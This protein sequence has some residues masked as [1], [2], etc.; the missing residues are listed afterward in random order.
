MFTNLT[1][2]QKMLGIG[3]ILGVFVLIL[4][5]SA[6]FAI[7][8]LSGRFENLKNEEIT[9]QMEAIKVVRDQN[10][11][12]RVTRNIMLGADY[13]KNMKDLAASSEKILKSFAAME[14][15]AG[16]EEEKKEV[17]KAGKAMQAWLED[18]KKRMVSLKDTP[19]EKRATYFHEYEKGVTPLAMELR[20]S[21]SKIAEKAE[22]DFD[23]GLV[24]YNSLAGKASTT[25]IMIGVI[26]V[27]FSA[28]VFL[29]L[30]STILK[31]VNMM[32]TVAETIASGDLTKGTVAYRNNDEMGRLARALESM[33]AT[34]KDMI[35]GIKTA[36]A[37][38]AAG[39]HQLSAS[40][41][42][43]TRN[44]SE[45][46]S[47]SSQI[48]TSAEEMTQT[49]LDVAKNA[50]T[51]AM[52][53]ADTA[54]TANDG[55]EVVEKSA[56]ES[57]SVAEVVGQSSSV[58]QTLGEKSKQIGE[59]VAVINDIA[60]Q[61]NLLALNAAIEAARAG[62]QGRGFAVV[63]DEV[64]KLAER[65]GKATA[66]I[67]SMIKSVQHEVGSA[68]TS[69]QQTT[70]QVQVGLE[71]SAQASERLNAIVQ[72]VNSLQG[73]VQQIASATEEMSSTSEMISGDVTAIAQGSDEI[74]KGSEQIA[75]SSSEIARLAG[76]LKSMV[77][78]FRV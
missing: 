37:S 3:C 38:L 12:S 25:I 4:L 74:S 77:D 61:T 2:K 6:T 65:T 78:K 68:V 44:M 40:A 10:F 70:G 8:A 24:D 54:K 26:V 14:R 51:I 18:G 28:T 30:I 46:A 57:K 50:S 31:P 60:D 36:S 5:G 35:S 23:A 27:I 63:A 75:Q 69:M 11:I 39:S 56:R 21:F 42:E 13:E 19:A 32:V 76:D 71:Y 58:V 15:A 66:E 43:I 16:T 49:V 53:A 20:G 62:E 55:A 17:A 7:H 48:A 33:N 67:S 9:M 72:S 52:S 34:L 41:E 47:R 45:Q 64:R 73:M 29:L 1:I 22:K 59:I